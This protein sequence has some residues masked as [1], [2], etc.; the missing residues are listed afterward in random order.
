[1]KKIIA[2]ILATSSLFF[3]T[4]SN[5]FAEWSAGL[6]LN[7][8]GYEADGSETE[9][10]EKNTA[11]SG[12]LKGEFNYPTIFVEYNT[13]TVSI[14][15]DYIP[16]EVETEESS[17]TDYNCTPL[18]TGND[19]GASGVVNKAKVGFKNHVTLYALV[20]V[21]DTGAFVRAGVIRVD[22]ET[23]E[24]LNTGFYISKYKCFWWII[25]CWLSI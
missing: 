22:V 14:G 13:G 2:I 8:G 21:M 6:S 4:V 7:K 17:R 1:M 23:K 24:T 5:T 11:P 16:G 12:S 25:K 19:G 20:P 15:L 9:N 3:L 10:G 18:C